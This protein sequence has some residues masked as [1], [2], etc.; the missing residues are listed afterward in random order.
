M[1]EIQKTRSSC[2]EQEIR[3]KYERLRMNYDLRMTIGYRP[4]SL[5]SRPSCFTPSPVFG[6][7]AEFSSSFP[8]DAT[9]PLKHRAMH[10]GK[11][12][13]FTFCGLTYNCIDQYMCARK[14][15]F[16]G[17]GGAAFDHIMTCKKP[18]LMLTKT[19]SYCKCVSPTE[20]AKWNVIMPRVL[21]SGMLAKFQQNENL[22]QLLLCTGNFA[23]VCDSDDPVLGISRGGGGDNLEGNVLASVRQHFV[24][25]Q[26]IDNNINYTAIF[27]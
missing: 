13:T 11:R 19:E 26:G 6:T 1:S 8:Y 20:L 4:K 2:K 14:L 12:G 21:F 10:M 23:L 18:S 22:K 7:Y 17:M 16:F 24:Y 3:A 25:A 27:E 15:A 9:L 5:S